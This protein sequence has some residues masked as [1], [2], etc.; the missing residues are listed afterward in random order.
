M[1]DVVIPAL[2]EEKSLPR[3]LGDLPWER[4]RQ[5][6]VVDNGSTDQTAR[7]A[8]EAGAR[9][10][11]EPQRGYGAACLRGI[12]VLREDPP[13]ILVFLD[14]DYSDHPEELLRVIA[15][16]EAGDAELVIGSRT[17]G[18]RTAGALLPQARLGNAL[19]CVLMEWMYDYRFTDLGPFRAITWEA[20][21]ALGMADENYGWTVEMQIKAARR[22]KSCVEVPVSYRKRVGTS[23]VTGTVRGTVLASVKILYTLGREYLDARSEKARE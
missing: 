18:H 20:L 6:L 16:I 21:E 11:S 17:L 4:I 7:V 22:Q 3:V 5:V 9:V 10:V 1:V 2:N 15:P 12:E 23:K 13:E 14:G 19:A 8:R